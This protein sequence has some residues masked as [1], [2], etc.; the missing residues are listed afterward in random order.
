MKNREELFIYCAN[1]AAFL[2][3]PPMGYVANIV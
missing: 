3:I 1:F 2:K